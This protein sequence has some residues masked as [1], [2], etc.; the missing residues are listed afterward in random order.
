MKRIVH[1]GAAAVALHLLFAEAPALA[2]DGVIEINQAKV[3]KAG[4]FPYVI[5]KA[6]SYR[7]TSNLDITAQPTPQNLTVVKIIVGD[8]T[9]DLSGF[10]IIGANVCTASGNPG[11]GTPTSVSCTKNGTGVGVSDPAD[12]TTY[13]SNVTVKNG[14]VRGMG[15]EGIRLTQV[16]GVEISDVHASSNGG[17]GFYLDLG[18]VARCTIEKNLNAGISVTTG[19]VLSSSTTFNGK[20]GI[21]LG[22]GVAADNEVYSNGT[23]GISMSGGVARNNSVQFNGNGMRFNGTAGYVGNVLYG[24]VSGTVTSGIQIGQNLCNGSTTCP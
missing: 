23:D 10:A 3:M 9:L 5:S 17:M 2:S 22:A 6:G 1:V 11:L 20:E 21:G 24:N 13:I 18:I 15:A 12:G 7:L 19:S 4:G 8:V 14:T 16:S